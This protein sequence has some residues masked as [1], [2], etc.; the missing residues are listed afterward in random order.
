MSRSDNPHILIVDDKQENLKILS[1]MLKHDGF[2][3][4]IAMDGERAVNIARKEVPDI[5][6]LDIMMPKMNGYE[7]CQLI[8]ENPITKDIPVIFMSALNETHNKVQGLKLGAVDYI[9]KPFQIAE[10]KARIKTHL[11]LQLLQKALQEKNQLLE[12][13]I[14][15]RKRA[16][17][18][19]NDYARKLE[20]E[21]KKSDD[22]LLNLLPE[23]VVK[24]LK[25]QG[26]SA[27]KVFDNVSI[28]FADVVD[29]TRISADLDPDSLIDELSDMFSHFDEIMKR[30][31]CER[32]KTI[33]D[34]YLAVSGMAQADPNHAKNMIRAAIEIIDYL[35]HRNQVLDLDWQVRIGIHSGKI[36]GGIVGLK[37]YIYDV[38]GDTINV[39]SRMENNSEPMKINVSETT[40]KLCRED[41]RF[42][43]REPIPIKGKKHIQMYFVTGLKID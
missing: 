35:H 41:F 1:E 33:G 23:N 12:K 8:K 27:P 14:E 32:I 37:K 28:M 6:L 31:E 4:L 3:L 40:Y 25:D 11:D 19:L 18:K 20:I 17:D 30:N 24:D 22:L 16:E 34:A 42:Q 29:F 9:T 38:F 15:E 21:Q 43:A 39:A 2:N 10:V 36:V 13:E 5:I 7:A 26:N